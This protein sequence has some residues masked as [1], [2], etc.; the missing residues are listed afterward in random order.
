MKREYTKV[1]HLAGV[2]FERKVRGETNREIA[3]S[4]GLTLK[5]V[6]KLITRENHRERMIANG[7]IPQPKGRPRKT[8]LTEAALKDN[9]IVKLQ[10]ENELLRNFLSELGRR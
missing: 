8:P 1:Q 6:K 5:Q 3:V 10:M 2:I 7:Y 4:L 9:K